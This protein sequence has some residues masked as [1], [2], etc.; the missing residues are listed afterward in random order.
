MPNDTSNSTAVPASGSLAQ[1]VFLTPR[2]VDAGTFASFSATLRELLA[3]AD[4]RRH[5]LST[6]HGEVSALRDA[7]R[8]LTTEL[9]AKLMTAVK[10]IPAID[11]RLGK[12]NDALTF[13]EA[14]IRSRAAEAN[15]EVSTTANT[16]EPN[17]DPS[18][19][20]VPITATTG[21]T[22]NEESSDLAA[23]TAS[24]ARHAEERLTHVIADARGE[25]DATTQV[26]LASMQRAH[27]AAEEHLHQ[28]ALDLE[29]DSR[30]RLEGVLLATLSQVATEQAAQISQL[31]ESQLEAR[32]ESMIQQRVDA[33]VA[34]ALA[35]QMAQQMSTTLPIQ[36]AALVRENMNGL[37]SREPDP[38]LIRVQ[39]QI[40]ELTRWSQRIDALISDHSGL[41]AAQ[42]AHSALAQIATQAAGL[43][44]HLEALTRRAEMTSHTLAGLMAQLPAAPVPTVPA[45]PM[46]FVAPP[47]DPHR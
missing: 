29:A 3:D 12:V 20:P 38:E 43:G 19:A 33:A 47:R 17:P 14:V 35:Q 2:V 40:D 1:E 28:R 45:Q 25:L 23:A 34:E 11:Q 30:S 36:V 9:E 44:Q 8:A 39:Q 18:A 32:L 10:V 13:A 5:S 24:V 6:L 27:Q 16:R 31:L 22:P 4:E 46:A 42:S 26:H 41:V 7:L 15:A 21:A 37:P